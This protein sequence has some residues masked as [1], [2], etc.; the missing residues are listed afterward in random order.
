M[1]LKITK[2][3]IESALLLT[4]R[5]VELLHHITSYDNESFAKTRATTAYQGA[6]KEEILELMKDIREKTGQL[7]TQGNKIKLFRD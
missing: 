7:M 3:D 5:E 2:I 1:Q 6:T 4:G